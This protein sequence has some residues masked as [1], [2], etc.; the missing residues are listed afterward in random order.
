MADETSTKRKEYRLDTA[1][2]QER[3][4]E[5]QVDLF[6]EAIENY[7]YFWED[8]QF[9]YRKKQEILFT[10]KIIEIFMLIAQMMD[11][12]LFGT[13]FFLSKMKRGKLYKIEMKKKYS[14]PEN[15]P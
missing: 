14:F 6:E 15:T 9:T 13:H 7:E 10:Q 2:L 1:L 12:K 4:L 3:R 11:H 5:Q 8:K